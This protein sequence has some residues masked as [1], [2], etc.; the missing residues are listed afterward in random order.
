MKPPRLLLSTLGLAAFSFF[1]LLCDAAE[2]I[3]AVSPDQ[4]SLT[5]GFDVGNWKG[6]EL[7]T[8]HVKAGTHA[9]LWKD[10]LINESLSSGNIPHDWTSY[11]GLKLWIYNAGKPPVSFMIVAVSQRDHEAFSYYAHRVVVDW[12][13]WKEVWIP[14]SAFEPN[15]DPAGW[16]KIDSLLFTSKGWALKP[17]ADAVLYL[18]GLR[19]ANSTP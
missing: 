9:A 3:Q 14:F 19:L 13:G 4:D 16:N 18:D 10:H 2:P 1:T 15:R 17:S 8:E 6:A 12:E 5:I 11:N 7:S